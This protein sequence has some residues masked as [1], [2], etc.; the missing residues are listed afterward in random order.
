MKFNLLFKI[1]VSLMFIIILGACSSTD[2]YHDRAVLRARK[3]LLE[4]DKTLNLAQIEYVKF[5]KPVIMATS[6]FRKYHTEVASSNTLSHVCIAWVIPGKKNAYVVFGV[7][8][9]RLRDWTPNRVIIKRYDK[10]ARKYHAAHR[11][12]IVFAMNNF[13]YLS[14]KQLNR[15]RFNVPE[16]II[17]DYK[18]G[19]DQL[20][21]K[22]INKQQ[23]NSLMQ[24][25]FVWPS[26]RSDHQLFVCGLGARDLGGWKPIFG[27]ETPTA[28]LKD[29]FL[30]A[31][32]FSQH[33]P[34]IYEKGE[35]VSPEADVISEE[36][37]ILKVKSEEAPKVKTISPIKVVPAL[38]PEVKTVPKSKEVLKVRKKQ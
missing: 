11:V 24:I 7:S 2:Y 36:K 9:N 26:T 27:G 18:F 30:Q 25:T 5:N 16:T 29:H 13:L 17:T 28:G 23:L 6:I 8:D 37:P 10:P 33:D 35:K 1:L 14:N 38:K 32:A 21:A 20:K 15:I 31:V 22:K 3:F 19:E 12:A 4:E 34:E